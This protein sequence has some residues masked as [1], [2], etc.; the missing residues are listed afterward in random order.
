MKNNNHM[1]KIAVVGV[2]GRGVDFTT[3]QAVKC[4]TLIDWM[5]EKYGSDE[6]VVV[7]TYQWKKNPVK[8]FCNLISAMKQC[9]NIVIMPA[10]HGV[11]VFAPLVRHFNRVFRRDIHYIVIGGWLAE[12]LK[13]NAALKKCIS[14]YQ[15]V[16]VEAM[17]MKR[18]LEDIGLKNI[19]FMPNSRPFTEGSSEKI[20]NNTLP[21]RVCTYSRVVKSKGIED[22]VRI[23]RR[24]NEILKENV[25]VLD[26]YGKVGEEYEQEFSALMDENSQIA[27]YKG[28]KNADETLGT[29]S[30][31]FALLFPT[32]YEGECF[33][34]TVLD[35][36]AA[37]LPIIAND[38]KY[39]SEIITDGTDGF[40]YPFRDIE[41][42]AQQLAE[43]YRD[44]AL[45]SRI[46]SGC[47]NSAVRYSTE[48][49]MKEFADMLS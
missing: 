1:K 20:H 14:T 10:Q 36:F 5:K 12:M 41:A 47:K 49:V 44:P 29:L 15:G 19:Y 38:W 7:N 28:C 46:Q 23:C 17:S 42:A 2:Y 45:Y 26:V 43:L 18:N 6:V 13:E 25:F 35:A 9:R 22:A 8:L 48:Y 32:Y 39:N 16:H 40:I 37:E 24:T 34:G 11:K 21:L 30:D 4:H 3:G 31:Y 27:S 33:A